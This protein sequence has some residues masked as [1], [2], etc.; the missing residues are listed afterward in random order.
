MWDFA[1]RLQE[2][3]REG[4]LRRPV[5]IERADAQ[6]PWLVRVDGR[7]ARVFC[8]NDYLGLRH[9]P[10]VLEAAARAMHEFGAGS[11]A[12]RQVGGDWPPLR[13]LEDALASY[14]GTQACLLFPSGYLANV[15]SLAALLGEPDIVFSDE[16][17]HA[18]LID[19]CRLA[20]ARIVVFRHADAQGLARKLRAHRGRRHLLVTESVFSMD[21]DCAPL[22]Q[23]LSMRAS[24]EFAIYLD[25]AHSLG[26]FPPRFAKGVDFRM[27]TLSKALG[28]QGAFV[29]GG[30][31]EIEFLRNHARTHLFETALSPAH[32]AAALVALELVTAEPNRALLLH[33]RGQLFLEALGAATQKVVSSEPSA[34]FPFVLGQPDAATQCARWLLERGFF[35]AAIRPP[36]V[37]PGTSRLRVTLSAAHTPE[38]IRSLAQALLEA[39]QRF[40]WML[41]TA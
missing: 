3:E 26:I 24:G 4:R 36:T 6:D 16:R 40:P 37:A 28:S 33:Q 27:G 22:A 14:L 7:L 2:I 34:I 20:R 21:G 5:P 8:S 19:G 11:G 30:R 18:S 29:A 35:V 13:E 41:E 25:E 23:Y 17:N 15:G 38:Q 32:A 31:I 1:D 39:R 10:A 9:H 12:A